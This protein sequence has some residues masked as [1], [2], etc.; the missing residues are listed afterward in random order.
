MNT[1]LDSRERI[2][3]FRT[4]A[5]YNPF[6]HDARS[7]GASLMAALALTS[8]KPDWLEAA[9]AEIRYRL[10]TDSTDAVLLLRGIILNLT[11]GDT[12]EADFY[13]EQYQRVN[14]KGSPTKLVAK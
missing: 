7:V 13:F 3:Y 12:K 4:A 11:L 1:S 2:E 6:S 9:R 10:Q 5:K 14:K 8:N